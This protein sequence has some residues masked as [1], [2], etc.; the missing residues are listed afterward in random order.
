M[1]SIYYKMFTLASPLE[2]LSALLARKGWAFVEYDTYINDVHKNWFGDMV[3]AEKALCMRL[4]ELNICVNVMYYNYGLEYTREVA[5]SMLL[6]QVAELLDR[7]VKQREFFLAKHLDRV[8]PTLQNPEEYRVYV[9]DRNW[10][11]DNFCRD[12]DNCDRRR[13]EVITCVS[14]GDRIRSHL[15]VYDRFWLAYPFMIDNV[16][17]S[18]C[19]FCSE[20][21]FDHTFSVSTSDPNVNNNNNTTYNN[22]LLNN[23]NLMDMDT[24]ALTSNRFTSMEGKLL[25]P[26][27]CL[28]C[29]Q[30][31]CTCA[32]LRYY[33]DP[34]KVQLVYPTNL[35]SMATCYL[36]SCDCRFYEWIMDPTHESEVW[37]EF[38]D[39]LTPEQ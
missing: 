32:G 3:R 29:R 10:D 18:V 37:S 30:V 20:Q 25:E 13:H 17:P 4:P 36:P 16:L 19:W 22:I 8:A 21:C 5:A 11:E 28:L 39:F 27:Y 2:T 24:T 35:L 1:A 34:Q 9:Q 33:N 23:E 12:L 38:S 6:D 31:V 14:C 7:E 26:I 15:D